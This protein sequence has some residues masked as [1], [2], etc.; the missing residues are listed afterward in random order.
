MISLPF[1]MTISQDAVRRQVLSARPDAPVVPDA[2]RAPRRPRVR[3][4]RAAIA[5]ALDRTARA[6][7]PPEC[8]PVR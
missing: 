5:A 8:S 3:R 6:I 7:A 1:A 2:E 4:T